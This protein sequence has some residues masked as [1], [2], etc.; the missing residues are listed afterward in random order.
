MQ[1]LDFEAPAAAYPI[2]L[3]NGIYISKEELKEK[4]EKYIFTAKEKLEKA[5]IGKEIT[6]I[7][8][9]ISVLNI[10]YEHSEKN[11]VEG[12]TAVL[13]TLAIAYDSFDCDTSAFINAQILEDY[14]VKCK[15]IVLPEHV[16]LYAELSDGKY[17]IFETTSG[18]YYPSFEEMEERY[19]NRFYRVADYDINNPLF[20]EFLYFNRSFAHASLGN[21]NKTIQDCTKVIKLNSNYANAYNNRGGV[22]YEL[23]NYNQAIQD[24]TKAIKL[25][26]NYAKAYY[27]R[28]FVYCELGNYNKAIQDY[29]EAIKLNPNY[30]GSYYSRGIAYKKLGMQEKANKDFEM[31]EKLTK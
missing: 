18:H 7:D 12:H 25:N 21:Y 17:L 24:D 5:G 30:A 4:A 6:T 14:G 20:L 19:S 1:I 10:L 8:E 11:S 31:Y 26:P 22:Y 16:L 27:S 9:L 23:G 15:I 13:L 28:G 3:D 2:K 29:T